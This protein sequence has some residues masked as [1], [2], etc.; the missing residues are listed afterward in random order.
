MQEN[1]LLRSGWLDTGDLGYVNSE[2][3]LYIVDRKKD[4]I[5][6][7]GEKVCSYDVENELLKVDGIVEA[8]VVGI[9][10]SL[11]G[12]VPAAAVRL[13]AGKTVSVEEIQNQLKQALSKFK[14]PKKIQ[15]FDEMP[16]TQNLKVDKKALRKL[17]S[18]K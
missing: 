10:H 16:L 5:N 1:E 17:L 8:A 15:F 18:D 14:I 6:R 4:M 9:P 2:G 13:E 7:G 3:Y 11:Y 12:E